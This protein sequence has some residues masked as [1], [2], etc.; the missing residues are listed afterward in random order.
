MI[1]SKSQLQSVEE[2]ELEPGM[3]TPNQCTVQNRLPLMM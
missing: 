1:F 2:T 3:L